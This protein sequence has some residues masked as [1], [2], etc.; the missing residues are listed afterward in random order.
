[1]VRTEGFMASGFIVRGSA[2][3]APWGTETVFVTASQLINSKEP[4][5]R[6][7]EAQAS[8]PG[9]EENNPPIKFEEILWES[10]FNSANPLKGHDVIVLRIK[11]PLPFGAKPIERVRVHE[12]EDLPDFDPS[13]PPTASTATHKTFTRPMAIVGFGA[14]AE[15]GE[16][17]AGFALFL[18]NLIGVLNRDPEGK[19]LNLGYTQAARRELPVPLFSTLTRASS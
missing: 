13:K 19:P 7:E 16:E 18:N 10:A 14:Y 12:F 9:L 1:M 15:P 17:E 8:F 3:Y 6:P 5:H 4:G 11:D 2:L